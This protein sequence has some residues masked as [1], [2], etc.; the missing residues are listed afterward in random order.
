M[1]GDNEDTK[2]RRGKEI[3]E[4]ERERDDINQLC[5]I[6]SHRLQLSFYSE[7]TRCLSTVTCCILYTAVPISHDTEHLS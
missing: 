3:T 2:Q 4:E 7:I 6:L 5:L 1:R